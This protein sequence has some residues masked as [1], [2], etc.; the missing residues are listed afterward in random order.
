MTSITASVL[1]DVLLTDFIMNKN[2]TNTFNL[3]ANWGLVPSFHDKVVLFKI[4]LAL[5]SLLAREEENPKF[6]VVREHLEK[7]V[8]RADVVE[9]MPF[10]IKVKAAMNQLSSLFESTNSSGEWMTWATAWLNETGID[11]NNPVC[12]FQFAM[13]WIDTYVT[14]S[15]YLKGYSPQ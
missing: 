12:A 1:A 2:D 13:R 14:V 7:S 15:D 11:E 8:F 3:N 4:A 6:R 5:L 9:G 10:F